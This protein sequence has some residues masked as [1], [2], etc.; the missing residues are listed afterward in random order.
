MVVSLQASTIVSHLELV[1]SDSGTLIDGPTDVTI[2]LIGST[3]DVRWREFHSEVPF[4]KGL[5]PFKLVISK[6][7]RPITFFGEGVQ[8]MVS[9]GS[10]SISLPMHSTPFSLFSHSA[11]VVN[12]IHM[13]GVF[14]TDLVNKRIGI[15][16]D[17][18]T[19]SALLEVRGAIRVGD[20]PDI[21]VIGAIRWRDFRLDG[22]HNHQWQPLD[23]GPHDD[24][25]TKWSK[26]PDTT[27]F[28]Y[29]GPV[30]IMSD[31]SPAMLTV[32]GDVY[33]DELL[34]V[35]EALMVGERLNLLDDYGVSINSDVIARSIQLNPNNQFNVDDGLKV[36]GVLSGRADG[37]FG[38]DSQHLAQAS[39]QAHE[40]TANAIMSHHLLSGVITNSKVQP[41]AISESSLHE[42]FKLTNEYF[43]NGI[44]TSQ[45]IKPFSIH[46]DDFS[47]TFELMA[48]HFMDDVIVS[49]NVGIGYMDSVKINDDELTVTD[50]RSE[51]ID[52]STVLSDQLISS[53]I[54]VDG[55]IL[56]ED[57]L[58]GS[59]T[60]DHFGSEFL[61]SNG[62]TAQ[63]SY[64]TLD[65][66]LL[67]V[68]NNQFVSEPTVVLSDAGL[69][70]YDTDP[71]QRLSIQAQ[72]GTRSLRV[73]SSNDS[74]SGIV[75]KNANGHWFLGA[76]SDTH[77]DIYSFFQPSSD[78]LL[79]MAM[80][81][82]HLGVGI[83]PGVERVTVHG[84]VLLGDRDTS[85]TALLPGSVYFSQ[86]DGRF[87]WVTDQGEGSIGLHLG[88]SDRPS[89]FIFASCVE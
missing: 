55:S 23:I 50:F 88:T 46:E 1:L 42:S 68:S 20:D 18:P 17:V 66:E 2:S 74:S 48:F 8:L 21:D 67:V 11:N 47:E 71:L 73:Q 51:V 63:T 85:G 5:P 81:T 49:R 13:E 16:L 28:Y 27:N 43:L 4:L 22:R 35:G 6:K 84:A 83:A 86:A 54:I 61:I 24:L 65:G 39:I 78:H 60:Y 10:D 72:P 41:A 15:H 9:I 76:E 82:G 34:T 59:L 70:I 31:D 40:I 79:S 32:S 52:S 12:A 7:L 69:G 45:K 75:F 64:G 57:F 33:V 53:S 38:I 58:P 30:R 36:S 87:K 62:G 3:G 56:A 77:F 25:E 44:I 37:L 29:L 14:H 19:P 89:F 80:D 26:W